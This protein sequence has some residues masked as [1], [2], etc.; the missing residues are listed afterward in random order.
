MGRDV[1]RK[2]DGDAGR[3]VDE[4]VG[5]APGE[6]LRLFEGVVE[7]EGEA[8]GVLL[9]VAQQLE[10]ERLEARL[11]VAHGGGGVA[12][13]RAE[14]A[15]AVDEGH[16][17]IEVLRHAHHRVVHGRIAVRVVFAHALAHDARALFM[18][19]V[20]GEAHVVHGIEDAPLD[21]FEP[22]LH[23][24]QGAVEDDV[25]RIRQHRAGQHLFERGEED[26]PLLFGRGKI[27][28]R[29]VLFSCQR[30]ALPL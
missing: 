8:D 21:G 20:G 11:R 23:A 9:D 28:L 13:H 7:V 24:R 26:L 10:R 25:F 22:V 3:A 6:G 29:L 18:R 5:E 14:V 27:A 2:A 19:L 1:G 4:Q 12:V 17:H 15:V 30:S 16:A